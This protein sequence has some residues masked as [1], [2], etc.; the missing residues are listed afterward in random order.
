MQIAYFDEELNGFRMDRDREHELRKV[1]VDAAE[2]TAFPHD[3]EQVKANYENKFLYALTSPDNFE[4][5][6]K[7]I[8]G[9]YTDMRLKHCMLQ[10]DFQAKMHSKYGFLYMKMLRERVIDEL[11]LTKDADILDLSHTHLKDFGNDRLKYDVEAMYNL[12]HLNSTHA[13]G[14]DR[15]LERANATSKREQAEIA[16]PTV[17]DKLLADY[18]LGK[19]SE[20]SEA[21][22]LIYD[23]A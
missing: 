15:L 16:Q 3:L 23:L 5:E 6:A 7:Q 21:N 12:S 1:L 2:A 19:K 11:K 18:F 4:N 22:K 8:I 13:L 17:A 9:D 20:I 14:Y 10:P